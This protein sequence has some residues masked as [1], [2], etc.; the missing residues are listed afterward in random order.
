MTT[1]RH[2]P[3]ATHPVGR[4]AGPVP[5][6]AL[7]AA[8]SVVLGLSV[9]ALLAWPGR[10]PLFEG[11]A[12]GTAA[13]PLAGLAGLVADKGLLA[14]VAITAGLVLLTWFRDRP[15]FWLLAAA[16]VGAV[17]AYGTS[18]VVK[19]LVTEER[20]C[21]AVDVA[22]V[23]ACPAPGDWSWPSNHSTIAGALAVA[24]LLAAPRLSPLVVP[25]AVAV[26]GARVA[27]GVHYVHD[28]ACGL[29]LGVLVTCLVGLTVHAG[30]QRLRGTQG[31]T[32]AERL[33]RRSTSHPSPAARPTRGR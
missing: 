9:V 10:G 29:A 25:L 16:G 12:G 3:A 24:C 6:A 15:R 7:P 18:E 11:I 1:T 2:A 4:V 28:V 33:T 30:A 14:L 21:R 8:L 13:S 26:A 20:P 32:G 17:A 19:L 27:A 31:R 22:T 23:L 5:R